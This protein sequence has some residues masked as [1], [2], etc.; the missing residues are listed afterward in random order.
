MVSVDFSENMLDI[1]RKNCSEYPQI[2]FKKE[3]LN[4]LSF[5][6]RTFGLVIKRLVPDC[7]GEIFRVLGEDGDFVNFTN[8]ENDGKELKDLFG[9]PRHE[10]VEQ[11][12]RR[13]QQ[14]GFQIVSEREFTFSENY[15]NLDIL[16]SMLR[17]AP[18]L[19]DFPG[20][21]EK[22]LDSIAKNLN[23][24]GSFTLTRHKFLT[25]AKK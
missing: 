4:S 24:D 11:Y 17:I 20:N 25:H 5:D 22:Y 8:G 10:S 21:E 9:L 19:G 3:N 6:D 18:I 14:A 23:P 1:A 7:L 16:K 12:R 13:L 15:P 2:L